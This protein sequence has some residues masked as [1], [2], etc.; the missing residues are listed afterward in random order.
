MLFLQGTSSNRSAIGAKIQLTFKENAVVRNVF[1]DLNSG[2]SFGSSPLRRE[3][4]IGK[5]RTPERY[6]V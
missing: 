1:R 5:A 6:Y 4:G 3:I 2:G